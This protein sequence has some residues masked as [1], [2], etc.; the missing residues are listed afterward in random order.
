MVSIDELRLPL[1]MSDF[2]DS[3]IL[4]ANHFLIQHQPDEFVLSM[5][6]VTTPPLIGAPDQMRAQARSHGDVPVHTI[7]RV[8]LNRRRIVELIALLQERLEEHDGLMRD[9][10]PAKSAG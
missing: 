4:L 2:D 1:A 5:S 6:Q 3:P 8:A 10:E 9:R 7:A